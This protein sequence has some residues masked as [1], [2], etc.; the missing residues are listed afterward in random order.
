M[1]VSTN[2]LAC[3]HQVVGEQRGGVG[4]AEVQRAAARFV[5]ADGERRV[6]NRDGAYV[7]YL[8]AT[9]TQPKLANR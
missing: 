7:G 9:P 8:T 6:K 3:G 5:A 4:P 1:H 2:V